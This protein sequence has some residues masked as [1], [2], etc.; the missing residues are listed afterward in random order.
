MAVVQMQKVAILGHKS[1]KEDVLEILQAQG[2]LEVRDA[3]DAVRL[4]HIEVAYRKA[5]VQFAIDVLKDAAS[6]E[7]A[8]NAQK[9]ATEETILRSVNH[10]DVRGIVEELRT[11][12]E[13][14]TTAHQELQT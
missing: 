12:E 9:P 14:D 10:T 7:T 5:D 2:V 6:K 13:K 3:K 1:I 11:L 4:D 8:A